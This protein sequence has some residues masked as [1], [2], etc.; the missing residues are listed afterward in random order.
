[1]GAVAAK[2]REPKHVGQPTNYSLMNE[3]YETERIASKQ[4]ED[5]VYSTGCV[6]QMSAPDHISVVVVLTVS[7]CHVTV[8][9]T[10]HDLVLTVNHT[11]THYKY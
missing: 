5:H 10:S 2:L 9:R 6:R 1:V 11:E 7:V 4:S 3:V 8:D